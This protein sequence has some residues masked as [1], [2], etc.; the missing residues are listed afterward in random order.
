[1]QRSV[2][3]VYMETAAESLTRVS[4]RSVVSTNQSFRRKRPNVVPFAPTTSP[5]VDWLVRVGSCGAA[6]GRQSQ[7]SFR[8]VLRSGVIGGRSGLSSGLA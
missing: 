2:C 3:L 8:V 6:S 7:G 1:M 5:V 4:V